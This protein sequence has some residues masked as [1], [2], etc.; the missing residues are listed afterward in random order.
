MRETW[1]EKEVM[2]MMTSKLMTV[3]E[4]ASLHSVVGGRGGGGGGPAVGSG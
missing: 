1:V 4:E 2:V 3:Y